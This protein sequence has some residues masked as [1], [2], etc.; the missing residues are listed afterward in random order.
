[1]PAQTQILD[2]QPDAAFN[3]WQPSP[4]GEDVALYDVIVPDHPFY[5]STLTAQEL[6][7]LHLA[8]PA[9]MPLVR[10]RLERTAPEMLRTRT[11]IAPEP[12][13]GTTDSVVWNDPRWTAYENPHGASFG[14]L[15]DGFDDWIEWLRSIL[16]FFKEPFT[17]HPPNPHPDLDRWQDDGGE[18]DET[19]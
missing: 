9:A 11:A 4:W 18:S 10:K 7:L 3:G 6:R 16:P 5:G 14:R 12:I 8:V 2:I 15:Q 1:M 19:A 13:L 17:I